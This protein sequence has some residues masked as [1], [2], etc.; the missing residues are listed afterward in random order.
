VGST[1]KVIGLDYSNDAVE[2]MKSFSFFDQ[3][4][5]CDAR[6]SVQVHDLVKQHTAGQMADVVINVTN[7][8]DTEMSCILSARSGGTVY[9]FSMATS[10]TKATLGAEGVGAHVELIMGNGYR[11]G[12]AELALNILRE[13]KELREFYEKKYGTS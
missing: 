11:P 1:G 7:I 5:Q 3:A 9:F 4:Y 10:F 12:H 13:S 2:K 8:P 6:A